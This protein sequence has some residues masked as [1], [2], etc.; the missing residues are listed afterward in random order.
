MFLSPPLDG[1]K[2]LC[3]RP[4]PHHTVCFRHFDCWKKP[5]NLFRHAWSHLH[6]HWAG[7]GGLEVCR[8]DICIYSTGTTISAVVLQFVVFVLLVLLAVLVQKVL[9][10]LLVKVPWLADQLR[11]VEG[12]EGFSGG[13]FKVMDSSSEN[14]CTKRLSEAS[15]SFLCEI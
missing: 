12:F 13:K 8:D 11:S 1:L 9:L 5:P 15:S 4:S 10:V 7:F 2:E 14:W 3:L 6:S